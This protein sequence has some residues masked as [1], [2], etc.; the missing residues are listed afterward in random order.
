MT[1]DILNYMVNV[2]YSVTYVACK[3]LCSWQ[4]ASRG[5]PRVLAVWLNPFTSSSLH[6]RTKKSGFWRRVVMSMKV[7]RLGASWFLQETG[8]IALII[9]LRLFIP[10][11]YHDVV[12]ISWTAR[13]RCESKSFH[14]LLYDLIIA[15]R[16][17]HW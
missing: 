4:P 5:P 2:V 6:F 1:Q 12:D 3:S 8:T 11:L 7:G 17:E 16:V 15:F 9:Y 14:D 10:A 13:W